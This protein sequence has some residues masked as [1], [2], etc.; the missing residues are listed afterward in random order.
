MLTGIKL[1]KE[2]YYEHVPE[3]FEISHEGK[4]TVLW[5]QQMKTENHL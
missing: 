5:N 1:N 3:L 2:H 4:V